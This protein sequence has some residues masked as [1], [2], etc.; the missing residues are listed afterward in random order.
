MSEED[1]AEAFCA[2]LGTDAVIE[3][4][5]GCGTTADDPHCIILLW[6]FSCVC[7]VEVPHIVPGH[8]TTNH[9]GPDVF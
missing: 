2:V 6:D 1:I 7:N 3:I 8:H 4:V 5:D 9:A